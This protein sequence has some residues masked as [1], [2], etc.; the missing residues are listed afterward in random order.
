VPDALQVADR[1]HL[2]QNV[3][4][5]LKT[6][7]HSRRWRQPTTAAPPDASLASTAT[8]T[9]STA[10]QHIPQPTPRKRAVWEAVQQGRGLG[11]SLRQMAQALGRD[12][13]TVRRYVA[14]DEPPVYPA[15][16]PRATQL[17]PYVD[18]RGERWAQGCHNARRL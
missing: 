12:R 9:P 7:L 5:T 11:Q 17:T 15:R 1:F 16:R 8:T 14:L 13:W 10:P 3:G 6:L 2:V 4:N 18:Y